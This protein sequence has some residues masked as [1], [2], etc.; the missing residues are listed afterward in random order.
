MPLHAEA[1][2]VKSSG[3]RT[4]DRVR[5]WNR[6]GHYYLGL[7]FLFF[8]W[9]F[10]FTGLLL[11]HSW[12]FAEFW[13]SRKVSTFERQV[14]VDANMD[15]LNRARETMRQLGIEGEIEW[16]S[17]RVDANTFAFRAT[18]PGRTWNVTLNPVLS[19]ASVERTDINAWGL[20][21]VLHTFT[22]VRAGDERNHRDWV[23]TTVWAISMDAVA[24]GMHNVVEWPVPMDRPAGQAQGW[25]VRAPG[26][27]THLWDVCR[28]LAAYLFVID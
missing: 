16:T 26:R 4:L 12:S 25:S 20:M 3:R 2:P 10:A 11:N 17:T 23:L 27:D 5:I 19:R 22:G 14:N 24:V 21:R 6:K 7:Y 15:D 13:P 28:W 9:L 18:R 1:T 8:L